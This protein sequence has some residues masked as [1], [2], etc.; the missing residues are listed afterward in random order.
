[1]TA[2]Q[3]PFQ[4]SRLSPRID[5]DERARLAELFRR[6]SL[7]AGLVDA[8]GRPVLKLT[9]DPEPLRHWTERPEVAEIFR[10]IL[11]AERGRNPL[12]FAA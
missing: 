8:R 7:E 3:T 11:E 5:P 4:S 12:M 10:P 9:P 6:L 2:T 1:M